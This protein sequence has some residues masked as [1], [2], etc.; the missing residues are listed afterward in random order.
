MYRPILVSVVAALAL[1]VWPP[2]ALAADFAET[3]LNVI[4][5]GQYQT[6]QPG[7]DA[8]AQLYNS[9]TPRFDNVTDADLPNFFKSA[10]LGPST[11]VS[12]EVV[13]PGVTIRRDE[14]NVPHV[15]GTTNDDVL[16]G[17]G[18]VAAS[19]RS[20]LLNQARYNGVTAAIDAPNLSAIDLIRNLY[21]FEPS[22]QANKIVARQTKVLQQAGPRGV[23][24]LHDIDVYLSGVN[25]WYAANSPQTPKFTRTDVYALNAVK[26]QFLGE[27]GGSEAAASQLLDGLQR[28]FGAKRGFAIWEDL[29]NRKDPEH[30][31]TLENKASYDTATG[32]RKGTVTLRNGTFDREGGL[33]SAATPT[34]AEASNIL[35]TNGQRSA[36]GRP[37]FVGGPQIGYFFP[38]LTHEIGLY[39]PDIQVRGATSVPFPGYM[40][41]GR[42][43]DFVWT[44][45]SAGG[46]IIDT[47]AETLCGGSR[48]K[49]LYKGR[50]RSM[51]TVNAG[52]LVKGTAKTTVR[53]RQTV[54]GP[55]VGYART[56]GG[57][58]VAIARKRS[59]YGRD[60][61]D[62]LFFQD[63]TYGRVQSFGD[64]ATAASRTPQTFNAF[65]ADHRDMGLYT[66]GLLPQR[67]K[68]A[69]GSLVTDGRGGY[70]W[71]G[72]LKS[73]KHPRG[74]NTGSGLIINWNN[75]P[76]PGFVSGDD[77][78]GSEGPLQRNDMLRREIARTEKHTLGSIVAAMNASA[79]QDPRGYLLWPVMRDLLAKAPAPSQLAT[80]M[81]AQLDAWNARR[82]PRIDQDR[83][84]NIDDA[85][86][87]IMDAIW[88]RV[89]DAGLCGTLGKSLCKQL[90]EDLHTRFSAPPG[91]GQYSGWHHYM[92]KDFRSLLGQKVKGAFSRRY[93]ASTAK[94][95]AEKLWKAIDAAGASLAA[96]LGP[97][98]ASWREPRSENL[99]KFSPLPL[100]EMDYTNRPSGIQ[101]VIGFNGHR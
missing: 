45:T 76:A 93:C 77:R 5:S 11:V 64:F 37:Q 16:F 51:E 98:P 61:L 38:G 44:L 47:Y 59:S 60:T 12:E 67:P 3:A 24:L 80:A 68:G 32:S 88:T 15:Y 82:A 30:T 31:S 96:S 81:A 71:K 14:Y 10:A 29:R 72:Y 73:S 2:G 100:I 83:D 54:H 87:P 4:P 55:V 42:G 101:Q 86:V 66:T 70:E 13:R 62:Q 65:Y 89:T 17:A 56:T 48:A 90:D 26:G 78:F 9:L 63:L 23:Q 91:G 52:T 41:I 94:A 43:E 99:I 25:A 79:T 69:D 1:M 53:F 95:C 20:L 58:T 36:N 34:R 21:Q 49:Y 22:A 35:I 28:R 92:Y 27:G 6:A 84:G 74:Q 50:C 46:D 7:A 75:R 85:G 97:D 33:S 40:L 57:K 19:D 8:Q 18:W 39:G